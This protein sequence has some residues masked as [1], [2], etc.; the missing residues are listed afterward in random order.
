MLRYH[1]SYMGDRNCN[2]AIFLVRFRQA[3]KP[4]LSR[5]KVDSSVRV[6]IRSSFI[7]LQYGQLNNYT[8]DK[9]GT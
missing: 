4:Y 6:Q 3:P 1:S 8:R 7:G 2:Q 9:D 5:D